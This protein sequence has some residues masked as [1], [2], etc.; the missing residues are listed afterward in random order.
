VPITI[1]G[2]GKVNPCKRLEI[3]PGP[4]TIRIG[5]PILTEGRKGTGRDRL[6]EEVKGAIEAGLDR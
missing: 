5:E 3:Y 1:N 4:I 2:S 6:M